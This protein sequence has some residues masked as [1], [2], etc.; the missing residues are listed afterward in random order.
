MNAKLKIF[1]YRQRNT[2]THGALLWIVIISSN[3]I[4][5]GIN[6]NLQII[7]FKV[8]MINIINER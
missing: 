6:I 4:Q 5:T 1:C 7:D 3:L 2:D 8:S